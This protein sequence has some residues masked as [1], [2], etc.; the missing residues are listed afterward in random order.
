MDG[1]FVRMFN[2]NKKPICPSEML[3]AVWKASSEMAGYEQQD[4]HEF[5][6]CLRGE[7]HRSL[8]GQQF[9]CT[10]IIHD[11]FAGVLQ[12]DL[13]CP[14]CRS[15]AETFD[16]FLDI[17]LDLIQH[18][19]YMI[20]VKDC[21]DHFTRSET[22]SMESYKCLQC[23][24]HLE[25]L[26]KR[27]LIRAAPKILVIHLK[28]FENGASRLKID[29]SVSF[30]LY[31][32][33]QNYTVEYQE[34]PDGMRD[35]DSNRMPPYKLLSVVAHVGS[36]DSGH[37]TSYVRYRDEWFFIDDALV[38]KTTEENVLSAPAYMLF[39]SALSQ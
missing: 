38:T 27:M 26:Q 29:K 18:G 13:T 25:E 30:P 37:Y 24:S 35:F 23:G 22:I 33:L 9:N 34:D 20:S 2:G 17:S 8:G 36:L 21:L 11:L 16:P 15:H 10:C 12:S 7:L 1:L 32:D 14:E 39:Y 19:N 6:L 28:R 5:F 4:A 31:L 3:Y